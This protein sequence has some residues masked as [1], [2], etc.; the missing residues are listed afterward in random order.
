MAA[1][2]TGLLPL[3]CDINPISSKGIIHG[4][5]KCSQCT[6]ISLPL[7]NAC[8]AV[9]GPMVGLGMDRVREHIEFIL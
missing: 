6:I 7:I 2:T 3:G 1:Q 4:A 5:F 8:M 9:V